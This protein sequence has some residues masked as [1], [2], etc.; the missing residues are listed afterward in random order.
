MVSDSE[1]I[2]IGELERSDFGKFLKLYE[3]A[4]PIEERRPYADVE[5]FEAFLAANAMSALALKGETGAFL[6][7]MTCWQFPEFIYVEHFAITGDMRGHGLGARMLSRL[8]DVDT[9]ILLE[10]EL[11]LT[12]E[13]RRRVAFYEHS[14]FRLHKE[15]K[16]LQPAYAYGLPAVEM[17][18]MTAGLD[19]MP[20]RYAL[21]N[22]QMAVYGTTTL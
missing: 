7:F 3:E 22:F 18:I 1:N 15:L 12:D 21:V 5:Q 16:Y 6:G 14:G 2:R 13:S 8:K 4:F 20:S 9:R 11:P 17:A 10:V 19:D